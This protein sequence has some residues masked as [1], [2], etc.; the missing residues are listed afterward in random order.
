MCWASVEWGFSWALCTRVCRPAPN[1]ICKRLLLSCWRMFQTKICQLWHKTNDNKE[2]L[3]LCSPVWSSL[4]AASDQPLHL[5]RCLGRPCFMFDHGFP[6]TICWLYSRTKSR[7]CTHPVSFFPCSLI[8]RN[9]PAV[10]GTLF[11]S[12]GARSARPGHWSVLVS[13]DSGIAW[14][15]FHPSLQH[16][17]AGWGCWHSHLQPQTL[18][19]C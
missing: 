13:V 16:R 15:C 11:P 2:G 5:E 1:S 19:S 7:V 4:T 12:P 9:L 18:R 6:K 17:A 14:P 8:E 3:W 10:P